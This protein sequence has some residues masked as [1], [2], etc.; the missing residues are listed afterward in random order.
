MLVVYLIALIVGGVLLATT[1]VLG[2][3]AEAD[4]DAGGADT[5]HGGDADSDHAG[6]LDL[7]FG[8]LPVTSLRFWTF[9]AAFFGLVGTVLTTFA[10][11]GTVPTVVAAVVGGYASGMIMDRAVKYLRKNE[12]DSSVGERDLIGAG[13]HVLV[14]VKTGKTGKVRV[15]LKG[16]TVDLL[17]ETD[18]DTE[19]AAGQHAMVLSLRDDGHVLVTRG[20]KAVQ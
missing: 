19:L 5:D 8:W 10:M 13:A 1:L 17:A 4:A 2:G 6:P 11:A 3:A 20:D 12:R 18:D 15:H 16:R 14:Q 7:V 9:F